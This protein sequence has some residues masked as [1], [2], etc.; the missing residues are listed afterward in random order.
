MKTM[1][2]LLPVNLRFAVGLISIMLISST[3]LYSQEK[4]SGGDKGKATPEQ[5][6]TRQTERM[7]E[8]LSLTAAQEP[9]VAA[10]NLKYAK[11]M[12][13]VRKISDTAVQRKTAKSLNDQKN[14][15]LKAVLTP[16]QYTSYLKQVEE[17]R[18]RRRE[19]QH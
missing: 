10:I 7:K 17:L 15:E 4:H 14:V 5:K 6:A 1:L 12:E 3:S 13:D 9:K 18:A 8:S 2:K 19:M 16:A 11:K